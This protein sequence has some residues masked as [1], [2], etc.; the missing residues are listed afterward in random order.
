MLAVLQDLLQERGDFWALVVLEHRAYLYQ[1]MLAVGCVDHACWQ[2]QGLSEFLSFHAPLCM[3]ARVLRALGG[4]RE[5][6]RQVDAAHEHAHVE[7]VGRAAQRRERIAE[8]TPK[9]P[10]VFPYGAQ[11]APAAVDGNEAVL[12]ADP[13]C[14]RCRGSGYLYPYAKDPNYCQCGFDP[15]TMATLRQRLARDE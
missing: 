2:P 11:L 8:H 6:Q 10:K 12:R 7:E 9:E 5:I 1:N 15:M 4:E 13:E 14:E 3:Y